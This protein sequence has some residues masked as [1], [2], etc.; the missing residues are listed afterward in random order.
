[1]DEH[2]NMNKYANIIFEKKKIQKKHTT[3]HKFDLSLSLSFFS[4]T[5]NK[6]ALVAKSWNEQ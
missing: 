6:Q 4:K 5:Q 2:L 3:V 1:M